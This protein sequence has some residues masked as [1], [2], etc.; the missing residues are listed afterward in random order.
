MPSPE[1][2]QGGPEPGTSPFTGVAV[3][4]TPA[5]V[6]IIPRPFV[7]A[8]TDGGMKQM[9]AP[10]ALPL[11]SVKMSAA[12]RHVVGN[13]ATACPRVGVITHPKAMF[14]RLP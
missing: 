3:P 1:G 6:I 10:I 2:A 9:A 8:V 7:H 5:I 4:L 11:V 13:E 14:A 12:S